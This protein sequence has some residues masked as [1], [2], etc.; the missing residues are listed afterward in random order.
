MK[1]IVAGILNLALF[2]ISSSAYADHPHPWQMHFQKAA[3]PVMQKIENLHDLLLVI[4]FAIVAL[5]FGLLLYVCIKFSKKN[6]PIPST[7]S[8]NTFIEIIWTVVPLL[9]LIIVAIPSFKTLNYMEKIKDTELTLKV[10]GH[11]WY[12]NYQYPDNGDFS[13]DSYI[14]S[15]DQLKP[16]QIRLLE[17]DN[18]VVL[19]VDTNVR[20]LVTSY[21]VIHSWAIPSLGI[22]TD[23]VPGRTNET[24]VRVNKPGVYYGQCS[25]I[26]GIG[27]GFMPIAIEAVSKEDFAVWLEQSKQKFANIRYIKNSQVG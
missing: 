22:K 13:F 8:H 2:V 24:W 9:I 7:T 16:G 4:I 5:V 15:D 6:N 26:C 20:V 21:D 18:R 11:Q 12:W 23:A 19:P 10:V 17:V 3:S 27:H 14:I 1:N 25:E